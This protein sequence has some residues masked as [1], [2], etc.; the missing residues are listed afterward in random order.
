MLVVVGVVVE[1]VVEFERPGGG[2]GGFAFKSRLAVPLRSINC[3]DIFDRSFK[4]ESL[5]RSSVMIGVLGK[6]EEDTVL[7]E[8]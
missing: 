2:G 4:Q 1:V 8:T 5:N 3:L 7:E 6:S